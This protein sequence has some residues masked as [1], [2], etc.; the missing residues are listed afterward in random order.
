MKVSIEIPDGHVCIFPDGKRC[1]LLSEDSGHEI[2]YT[3]KLFKE[4][5]LMED[6]SSGKVKKCGQCLGLS[7][8]KEHL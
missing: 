4:P 8:L 7:L 3:C 1:P 2:V 5:Y 6:F